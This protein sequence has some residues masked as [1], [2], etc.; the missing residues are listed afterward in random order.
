MKRNSSSFERSTMKLVSVKRCKGGGGESR[1]K[2]VEGSRP[3]KV[4]VLSRSK[5]HFVNT[6]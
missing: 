1:E 6:V 4:N 5:L 2:R 3:A